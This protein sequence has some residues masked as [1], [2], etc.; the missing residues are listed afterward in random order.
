MLFTHQYSCFQDFPESH[1]IQVSSMLTLEVVAHKSTKQGSHHLRT[2]LRCI[3]PSIPHNQCCILKLCKNQFTK[4]SKYFFSFFFFNLL[5]EKRRNFTQPSMHMFNYLNINEN[6]HRSSAPKNL[7]KWF[8]LHT[9]TW[10]GS[11]FDG[12]LLNIACRS[13]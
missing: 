2:N 3:L 10:T 9:F 13:P 8:C 5:N 1:W 6:H 7:G 12:I 4:I 11:I